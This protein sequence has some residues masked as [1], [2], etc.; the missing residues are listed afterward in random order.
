MLKF[1]KG[2]NFCG[3]SVLPLVLAATTCS[4]DDHDRAPTTGCEQAAD[5]PLRVALL[6]GINE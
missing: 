5:A 4:A 1:L 6:V 3:L 2:R